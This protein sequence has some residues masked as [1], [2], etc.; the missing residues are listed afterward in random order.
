VKACPVEGTCTDGVTNNGE[1]GLDCGGPNCEACLCSADSL[2]VCPDGAVCF[3]DDDAGGAEQCACPAPSSVLTD[4]RLL[5]SDACVCNPDL[6]ASTPC[7]AGSLCSPCVETC[8]DGIFNN[9]EE[10]LDCGG[11]CAACGT[12]FDE[13][14]NQDEQLADCG[15]AN[16]APCFN[17]CTNGVQDPGEDGGRPD[18]CLTKE[19]CPCYRTCPEIYDD[20]PRYVHT[21]FPR[22]NGATVCES[23]CLAAGQGSTTTTSDVG[24]DGPVGFLT[25]ACACAT[26]SD[27]I[28]NGGETGLDCGGPDCE[29]CLCQAGSTTVCPDGAVCVL[30][31]DAGGAEQ[32]ACP[33]PSSVLTDR[34]LL[35]SDACVCN[36]A[37]YASTPCEAGSL[38]SPCVETCFDGISNNGEANIDCGGP[39][40]ACSLECD[41]YGSDIDLAYPGLVTP[42]GIIS[43]ENTQSCETACV[44]RGA[45]AS[46]GATAGGADGT[47]LEC[48]CNCPL[49]QS[50]C[51]ITIDCSDAFC[52]F[53]DAE[54]L[55]SS[56]ET[57]EFLYWKVPRTSETI[58][59]VCEVACAV[60]DTNYKSHTH[61][62]LDPDGPTRTY[63]C[64]CECR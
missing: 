4:R 14:R 9:E 23:V 55:G 63:T 53:C 18:C 29:A 45:I 42:S 16:C 60:R 26:C 46:R 17:N 39:C 11:P 41:I 40:A 30:D 31:D 8:F 19:D 5:Q 22:T 43:D 57:R 27:T 48:D 59:K 36:P 12:C 50:T 52:P 28:Q 3:L 20:C 61:D 10:G 58:R 32:C 6:Y 35:Q 33:A 64:I 62:D 51:D 1:T 49:A 34:R 13:I 2:T 56:G 15:G 25:C 7:E 38:C 37:L 24:E 47:T 21:S 44:Y 54:C